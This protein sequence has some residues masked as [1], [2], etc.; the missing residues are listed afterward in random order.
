LVDG[1]AIGHATKG[2]T[3]RGFGDRV[4]ADHCSGTGFIFNDDGSGEVAADFCA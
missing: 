3:I 4:N 2:M 1:K